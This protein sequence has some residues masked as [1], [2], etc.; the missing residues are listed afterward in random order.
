M[1]YWN[2]RK[3]DLTA[4]EGFFI[5]NLVLSALSFPLCSLPPSLLSSLPLTGHPTQTAAG[6]ALAW[7][8]QEASNGTE[9]PFAGLRF[10]RSFYETVTR[11]RIERLKEL[12][13]G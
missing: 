10:Q 6:K 13:Q 2:E 4:L 11:L 7:I 12:T 8:M 3:L 1:W 9:L 5:Q